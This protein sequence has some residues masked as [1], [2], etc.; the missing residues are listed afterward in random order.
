MSPFYKH[1]VP[2]GRQGIIESPLARTSALCTD[3]RAIAMQRTASVRFAYA[4]IWKAL[5]FHCSPL[6]NFTLKICPHSG[7]MVLLLVDN[8][9][10]RF[11][12]HPW[13]Q[14][15]R[16]VLPLLGNAPP[17]LVGHDLNFLIT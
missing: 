8:A 4:R 13:L 1:R 10:V 5:C 6:R 9:L 14:F 11:A 3:R 7:G 16:N 2:L 17:R 15:E 12:L